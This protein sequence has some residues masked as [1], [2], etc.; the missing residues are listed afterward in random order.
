[1]GSPAI[2]VAGRGDR[3]GVALGIQPER[4]ARRRFEADPDV[5]G[6]GQREAE[7]VAVRGGP[8]AARHR[9]VHGQR[10]GDRELVVRLQLAAGHR[11]S[12][13]HEVERVLAGAVQAEPVV[14]RDEVDVGEDAAFSAAVRVRA[15][16]QAGAVGAFPQQPDVRPTGL[17]LPELRLAVDVHADVVRVVQSTGEARLGCRGRGQVRGVIRLGLEAGHRRHRGVHPQVVGIVGARDA[18]HREEVV[19]GLEQQAGQA[20]DV[21]AVVAGEL[22]RGRVRRRRG[23]QP[24]QAQAP[25][26][27][28]PHDE[29]G[30][31]EDATPARRPRSGG[32]CP[33]RSCEPGAR[34]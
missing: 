34:P 10:F 13:R 2:G 23:R 9:A 16:P 32:S 33:G 27:A 8:D 6:R 18:G 11:R 25:R 20:R 14:A 12:E 21:L 28:R 31:E 4:G 3:R 15:D 24:Q 30:I 29:P 26:W 22:S 1:M 5:L 17:D 7:D 19:G